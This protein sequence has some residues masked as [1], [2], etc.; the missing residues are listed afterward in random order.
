MLP[1]AYDS[2]RFSYPILCNNN[3]VEKCGCEL[4]LRCF[5]YYREYPGLPGGVNRVCKKS[6]VSHSSR[7]LQTGRQ[8]DR[9]KSDID[10]EAYYVT[11]AN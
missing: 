11:L 4:F 5:F 2:F 10:S 6:S 3:S 9:R 1:I 8:T 7:A